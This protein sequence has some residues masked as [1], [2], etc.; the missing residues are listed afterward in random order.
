MWYMKDRVH[1]DLSEV[2]I[3][4]I[5]NTYHA[6]RKWWDY[7]DTKWFCKSAHIS[8]IEK[9]SFVLTPWRYVWIE[10]VVDDW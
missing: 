5:A 10:D 7:Q 9:H 6:W 8:E 2:D 4:K 3:E 1:K